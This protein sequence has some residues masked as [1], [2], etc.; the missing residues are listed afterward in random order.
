MKLNFHVTM[1]TGT[2]S[3]QSFISQ[4]SCMLED[5]FKWLLAPLLHDKRIYNK[6]CVVGLN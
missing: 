2:L 3:C 4:V 1:D 5:S 6:R